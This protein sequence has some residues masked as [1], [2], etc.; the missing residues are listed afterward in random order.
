MLDDCDQRSYFSFRY[1]TDA[2]GPI[3][4]HRTRF[5]SNPRNP[6]PPD[7][8][9]RLQPPHNPPVVGSIP[10]GPTMKASECSLTVLSHSG[11][12][13]PDLGRTSQNANPSR[14][15]TSPT[16][17]SMGDENP[18]PSKTKVW[19]SP[20]SPQGSTP[21]GR[22]ASRLLSK[23][24]PANHAK[25][26][27]G[28]TQVT[29]AFTPESIIDCASVSVGWLHSGKSG[30]I[31]VP[32]SFSARYERTSSKKRSPNTKC[33]ISS[34]SASSIASDIRSS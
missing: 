20:R 3:R 11:R 17:M 2:T 21:A 29:T 32:A 31:P 24:R 4:N 16:S 9:D 7:H 14:S 19:N 28:S 25:N 33:S 23:N 8:S 1:Q 30:E 12:A 10:T 34:A 27:E 26:R 6:T 22:S 18:G 13:H 5:L 15:T